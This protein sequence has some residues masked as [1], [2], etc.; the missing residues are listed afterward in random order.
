MSLELD[1]NGITDR[2]V[3]DQSSADY[4]DDALVEAIW[5]ELE[6]YAERERIREVAS[7]VARDFQGASITQFVPIFVRR[8]TVERLRSRVD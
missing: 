6:G 5:L 8:R 4:V 1:F 2:I 7:E 3:D